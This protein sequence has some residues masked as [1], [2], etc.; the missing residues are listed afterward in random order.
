[1]SKNKGNEKA[2]I[3][4]LK[5]LKIDGQHIIKLLKVYFKDDSII[6]HKYKI[7]YQDNFILFPLV[8]NTEVIDKLKKKLERSI[9]FEFVSLEAI[10]RLDYKYKSLKEALTGKIPD[11][12]FD[13][14]P[15]SY[16]IIGNIAILE[17]E[18]PSQI[19]DNEFSDYRTLIADAVINVNKNVQSVFEKKS[20]IKGD[21]RLRKFSH[22]SGDNKSETIHRENSCAFKLDIKKTYFS[23]R[24][25]YERRRISQIKIL[26]NEVIVD[27]FA[28]VGPFSI[29]IARLNPVKIH[30]FDINP[31]AFNYLQENIGLN[32]LEGRII[33]YN[34]N[35]KDLLNPS[36]QVG[37]QL[38]GKVDRIL[39]NLPELSINF[40]DVA[41]FLMKK[42][43]GIL[44]FYKFSEKPN[45][46]EK[47]IED[48][49]K[50][51]NEFNWVIV[52]IENSKIVK[53]YS[54]KTEL[55]VIGL[56]IKSLNS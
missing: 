42:S 26:E 39:M 35:V 8:E 22:L 48:L 31:H 2:E 9:S 7:S 29:Q 54:P 56:A 15:K 3:N 33:S 5:V 12:Q 52:E 50:K 6:D 10:G 27:M 13:L 49:N 19:G 25:V 4:F 51:L 18:K 14:I 38:S 20:K 34:I 21:Y 16:D 40:L 55:V 47:T 23:P 24:L 36:N 43:G 1:M 28:G 53:S 45:P 30:A 41:C 37:R 11:K 32:K 44:D 46:I 17:F